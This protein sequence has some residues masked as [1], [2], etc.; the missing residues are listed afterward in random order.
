MIIS[1][2]VILRIRN[3]SEKVIEKIKTHVLCWKA[4]FFSRAVY[5]IMWKNVAEPDMS[6]MTV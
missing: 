2:S 6:Q 5:E 1:R 4:Y 3:V